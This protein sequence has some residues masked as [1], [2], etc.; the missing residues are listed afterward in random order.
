M[1]YGELQVAME[2]FLQKQFAKDK[3]HDPAASTLDMERVV[4]FL[5]EL[6]K[7]PPPG[8]EEALLDL[9]VNCLSPGEEHAAYLKVSFLADVANGKVTCPLIT[10]ELATDLL[11]MMVNGGN[12]QPLIDLLADADLA[13]HAIQGLVQTFLTL[14]ACSHPLFDPGF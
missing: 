11:G 8:E 4:V 10:P 5:I 12:V 9:F 3:L 1:K 2:R 7:N 13:P 6:L 14:D